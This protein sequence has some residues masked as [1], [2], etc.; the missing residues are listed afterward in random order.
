MSNTSSQLNLAGLSHR[1]AEETELF[2][3]RAPYDPQFCYELFRLALVQRN[4]QAYAYLYTRYQPLVA[5]WIERHPSFTTSGE[6]TTYFTN[7]AFEKMW[8]A[9]K[10]EKFARFHD[11]KA[12]LGYLKLCT[13]SV[14]IDHARSHQHSLVDEEYSELTLEGY[15]D[16]RGDLEGQTV[17]QGQ[18]AQL[19]QLVSQ[20]LTDERERTV[21]YASFVMAMKP[22]EVQQHYEHLFPDVKTVY[23]TKQAALDRLRRDSNMA[24]LYGEW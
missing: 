2:F 4:Q 9:I 5:G 22:A 17:R 10:P 13:A 3:R 6:E 14:I 23:R 21:V 20:R 11:L 12:L 18:Q 19:W 7:R 1:C 24:Q 8:Q 15:A 16:S